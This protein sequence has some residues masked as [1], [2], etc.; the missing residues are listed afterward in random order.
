ML[1]KEKNAEESVE[2]ENNTDT[3]EQDSE[4]TAGEDT[5]HNESESDTDTSDI[6]TDESGESKKSESND[7]EDKDPYEAQLEKV[8]KE[9]EELKRNKTAA[10]KE[11]RGKRQVAEQKAKDLEDKA[12][13]QGNDELGDDEKPLTRKELE[14]FWS[15]KEADQRID[16]MT[17]NESERKLIREYV[18]KGY[19]V[20]DAYLKANSHIIDEY[21]N[22]EREREQ[23]EGFMAGYSRPVMRGKKGAPAYSTNPIKKKA[24]EGLTPEERKYL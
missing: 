17:T 13:R 20:D 6:D 11:E 24:A 9:N 10:I 4:N 3:E 15:Q 23:E 16:Q 21:K 22:A 8:Q 18:K 14:A 5:S 7:D 2:A 19:S 1:D 12:N